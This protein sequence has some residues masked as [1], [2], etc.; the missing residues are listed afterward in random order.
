M[1]TPRSKEFKEKYNA[2]RRAN[3][4]ALRAGEPIIILKPGRKKS[5]KPK[6]EPVKKAVKQS[7]PKKLKPVV[8]KVVKA[9]KP[10]K[11]IAKERKLVI[12]KDNPD[13]IKVRLD[14]KTEVLA[15]PGFD[16][17]QLRDKYGIKKI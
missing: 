2:R 6:V 15:L 11:P 5:D 10:D 8:P 17:N 13:A 7:K 9:R 16:I 4:A 12:P 14:A 1:S 3:R